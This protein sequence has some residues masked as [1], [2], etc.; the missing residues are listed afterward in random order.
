MLIRIKRK[1]QVIQEHYSLKA[2]A[3]L[4]S[5]SSGNYKNTNNLQSLYC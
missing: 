4:S 2:S 3:F 5:T 1:C